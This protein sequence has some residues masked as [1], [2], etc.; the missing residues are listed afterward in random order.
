MTDMQQLCNAE[1]RYADCR[2]AECHYAECRYAECRYAECHYNECHYAECRYA[3]CR[4]TA[5][6]A[7]RLREMCR[8][9]LAR[10]VY[11]ISLFPKNRTH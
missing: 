1:C 7:A 9:S 10:F 5:L 3:Q 11:I 2:Y 4:F 8:F 6:S